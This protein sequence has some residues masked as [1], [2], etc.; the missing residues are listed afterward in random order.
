MAGRLMGLGPL[1]TNRFGLGPGREM[2]DLDR[3]MGAAAED[4]EVCVVLERF[5][6][7]LWS[8]R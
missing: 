5:M 3:I 8:Y 6:G 1:A 2:V 7:R 4:P